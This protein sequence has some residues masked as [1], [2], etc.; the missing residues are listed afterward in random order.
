M[1][2]SLLAVVSLVAVNGARPSLGASCSVLVFTVLFYTAHPVP[3]GADVCSTEG[4][5][6]ILRWVV[7]SSQCLSAC[8]VF[9]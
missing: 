5:D 4:P 3:R 7:W 1:L 9:V 8:G 2:P 6:S